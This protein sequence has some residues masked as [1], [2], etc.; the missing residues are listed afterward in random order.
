MVAIA[1]MNLELGTVDSVEIGEEL[2]VSSFVAHPDVVLIVADGYASNQVLA[3]IYGFDN[4]PFSETLTALGASV[5]HGMRS[6]YART[7]LSVPSLLQMGY[8]SGGTPVTSELE[9]DLLSMLGGK[10]RLAEMMRGNGYRTVY[11]E[12]GWLG[13]SCWEGNDI[14]IPNLW[15]DETFYDIVSRSVLRDLPG[16]EIGMSFARGARH[17]LTTLNSTLDAYL[18]DD[19]PDF[20]FI[21]LLAPHPPL[22]LDESCRM[23]PDPALAGF[24]VA[25]PGMDDS[26]LEN[27]RA[28]YV[29]QVKCVN[30]HL[31]RALEAIVD[32]GA[33]ALMLSDHGPDH[34]LQMF[35]PARD[36]SEEQTEERFGIMFAAHHPGCDYQSL[37][38]LVNV[39]RRLVSCLSNTPVPSLPDQYF[40]LEREHG[41]S[42]IAKV[43]LP[44]SVR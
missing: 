37:S 2:S 34:G 18:D 41:Q 7:K 27:R 44:G 26:Q 29:A 30:N 38:T 19:R 8:V 36:W 10:N 39:G 15:P 42:T 35:E 20:V 4:Q 32:A 31:V 40:D 25:E 43:Q 24:M 16:L 5:N 3:E 21:H 11:V 23:S 13:T 1:V 6:N 22:F 9:S 33:V 28:A 12:S 17:V 14:C